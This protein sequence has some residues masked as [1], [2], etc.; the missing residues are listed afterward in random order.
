MM[1]SLTHIHTHTLSLTHTHKQARD[2]ERRKRGGGRGRE[3][4]EEECH[5]TAPESRR[6]QLRNSSLFPHGRSRRLS[7]SWALAPARPQLGSGANSS[8]AM[9]SLAPRSSGRQ[10]PWDLKPCNQPESS[11]KALS[12]DERTRRRGLEE[13]SRPEGR[14]K[15]CSLWAKNSILQSRSELCRARKIHYEGHRFK[16]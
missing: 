16:S 7:L 9:G 15:G 6:E 1:A 3:S 4:E 13:G 14:L 2:R 5:V 12:P 11:K 8:I 10:T